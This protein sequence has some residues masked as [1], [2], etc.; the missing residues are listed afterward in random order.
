[1]L[2]IRAMSTIKEIIAFLSS[3]EH[4][5]LSEILPK[6]FEYSSTKK[7]YH[8]FGEAQ[9]IY[10][11]GSKDSLRL[12]KNLLK[13]RPNMKKKVF[14]KL[15]P[16]WKYNLWSRKIDVPFN[17]KENLPGNL[18]LVSNRAVS[19]DFN[20]SKVIR[21]NISNPCREKEFRR[22]LREIGVTVPKIV[23]IG[24]KYVQEEL[25]KGLCR[26]KSL[27][28]NEEAL[29]DAYKD[30]I[31][32]Y[33]H[34]GVEVTKEGLFEVKAHGD[35]HIGNLG[36]ASNKTFLFD[37]ED[38]KREPLYYDLL[39]FLWVEY[40]FEDIFYRR[41]LESLS[42]KAAQELDVPQNKKPMNIL[43]ALDTLMKDKDSRKAE[44]FSQKVKKVYE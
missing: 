29:V 40:K 25:I 15:L 5:K 23:E 36:K 31:V 2:I 27:E 35:F 43:N 4:K 7:Y 24:N 44:E 38:R 3:S 1:M 33:N 19:I 28:G 32:F 14:L 10:F 6:E 9:E 21:L 12:I 30:L 41:Q 42:T 20:S 26:F 11:D 37:W 17:D 22:E 34:K 8:I 18:V 16:Y 13:L 39:Y